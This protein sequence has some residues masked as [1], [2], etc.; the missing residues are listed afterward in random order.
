MIANG[1][2]A[3]G[4]AQN[5]IT[6]ENNNVYISGGF[7]GKYF[8]RSFP[9]YSRTYSSIGTGHNA[10]NA[11]VCITSHGTF[12]R[13]E[14]SSIRYKN[15][16][17]YLTNNNY[18]TIKQNKKVYNNKNDD[19]DILAVLN[20]PI[21]RFKYNEGYFTGEKHFDY[22]Q[23]DLGLIAE[24]VAKICPECATY[25]TKDNQIIPESYNIKPLVIRM[26]YVIQKQQK[27]IEELKQKLT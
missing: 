11:Y 26:L 22:N 1:Y 5:N 6:S 3:V 17:E 4:S 19:S 23:K 14:S 18:S 10:S 12:G 8:L 13:Y 21:A 20:L 2:Y 16:V 15:S 27:E 9:V 24:D 25:I 7:D